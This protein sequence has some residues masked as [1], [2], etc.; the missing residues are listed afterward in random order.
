MTG[1]PA[2]GGPAGGVTYG[3]ARRRFLRADREEDAGA[4]GEGEDR[5]EHVEPHVGR[6]RLDEL[7]TKHLPKF[8][9]VKRNDA[10]DRRSVTNQ[11][12]HPASRPS[13]SH[14]Y[15]KA[16]PEM[17][18]ATSMPPPMSLAMGS[19]WSG[20]RSASGCSRRT[21]SRTRVVSA[22]CARASSIECQ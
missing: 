17:R 11:H 3:M 19:E 5:E 2:R 6:K 21:S 14:W 13:P 15:S 8:K 10:Y 16:S 1:S 12:A 18:S 7:R 4:R 9:A 22:A 20:H